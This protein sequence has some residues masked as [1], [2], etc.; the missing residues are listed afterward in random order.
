MKLP[1]EALDRYA[2]EY[3]EAAHA[4][5]FWALTGTVPRMIDAQAA[6]VHYPR[7]PARSVAEVLATTVAG[8]A[9][10]EGLNVAAFLADYRAAWPD[11]PPGEA[12]DFADA[13]DLARRLTV[14]GT[15][16]EIE[17]TVRRAVVRAVAL[18]RAHWPAVE[19]VA[20]RLV[21][22]RQLT[23]RQLRRLLPKPARAP[24]PGDPDPVR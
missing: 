3:H 24:A 12:E 11:T 16:A 10:T 18:L 14:A 13:R 4:V 1:P 6:R 2:T 21:E 19:R 23:A 15:E 7:R 9:V 5:V 20:S 17:A 22:D 8:Y